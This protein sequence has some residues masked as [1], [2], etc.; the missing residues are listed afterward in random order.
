MIFGP[1][2]FTLQTAWGIQANKTEAIVSDYTGSNGR[3]SGSSEIPFNF[4]IAHVRDN[5]THASKKTRRH[6]NNPKARHQS[7]MR[8]N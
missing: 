2:F 8:K 6:V 4:D 3:V 1:L 5:R 7:E